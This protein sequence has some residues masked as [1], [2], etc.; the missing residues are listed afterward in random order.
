MKHTATIGL[1]IVLASTACLSANAQVLRASH[2]IKVNEILWLQLTDE[3]GRLMSEGHRQFESGNTAEASHCIR[4]AAV[5]LKIDAENSKGTTQQDLQNA[6]DDLDAVA[7][8][9]DDGSIRHAA[10]LS[11]S[12]CR[13]EHALAEY[14]YGFARESWAQKEARLAGYRMRAAGTA[15][16]RAARWS[17]DELEEGGA[18]TIEATRRIGSAMVNGTDYVADEFGQGMDALGKGISRFGRRFEN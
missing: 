9:I 12:F 1:A 6:A 17:G 10:R 16:E 2:T 7:R 18:R 5:F 15:L 4:K 8:G 13:A 14:Q 3:P 11:Q